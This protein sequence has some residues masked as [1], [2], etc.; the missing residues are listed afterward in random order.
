MI[1]RLEDEF[2]ERVPGARSRRR[3]RSRRR[4][5]ALADL[6]DGEIALA[7]AGGRWAATDGEKVV[8]GD[9]A[10]LGRARRRPRAAGRWSPTT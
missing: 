10:D 9:A 6:A 8:T 4:R 7:I 3:S 2:D 1:Q 5:G